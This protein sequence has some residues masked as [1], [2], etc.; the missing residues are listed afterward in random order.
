MAK[1]K[2]VPYQRTVTCRRCGGARYVPCNCAF[3]CQE[4]KL[5][6]ACNGAGQKTVI[7]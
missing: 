7:G 1:G 6:P 2:F 5:C 3:A 4:T